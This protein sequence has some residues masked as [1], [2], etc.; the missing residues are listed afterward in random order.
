L[1][2]IGLRVRTM[3]FD[4]AVARARDVLAERAGTATALPV[5]RLDGQPGY[6]LVTIDGDERTLAFAAI[7]EGGELVGAGR[8]AR[9]GR[10]LAVDAARAREIAGAPAGAASRLV[11]FASRASASPLYP[12]WEVER[13]GASAWVDLGG[14]LFAER[15]GPG[16][17][18]G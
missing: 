16:R 7:G 8:P 4:E 10:H 11:W 5:A 6:W 18:G 12:L 13:A 9:R 14:T 15:P 17:P 1:P 2:R 3:T